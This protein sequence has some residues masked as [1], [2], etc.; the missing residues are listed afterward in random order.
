MRQAAPKRSSHANGAAR[1]IPI[2]P[3]TLAQPSGSR[4]L[5]PWQAR[6]SLL[7]ATIQAMAPYTTGR[8]LGENR[9]IGFSS[10]KIRPRFQN[11]ARF[12]D[13][14]TGA[15]CAFAALLQS[16]LI[17]PWMAPAGSV[18]TLHRAGRMPAHQYICSDFRTAANPPR[19]G[20]AQPS[21]ALPP[22]R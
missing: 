1:P 14:G 3:F 5:A 11:R 13:S 9:P 22:E 2:C 12:L 19:F 4:R 21:G 18:R 20:V 7:A 15:P 10:A 17:H 8:L 16:A 6:R